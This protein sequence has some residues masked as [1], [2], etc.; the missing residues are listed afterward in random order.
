V[1]ATLDDE[2]ALVAPREHRAEDRP[3]Q[4]AAHDDDVEAIGVAHCMIS[5]SK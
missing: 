5:L 4:P 3:G 1:R 2:H